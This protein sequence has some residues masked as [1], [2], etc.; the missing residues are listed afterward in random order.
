MLS[1]LITAAALLATSSLAGSSRDCCPGAGPS[2]CP[3]AASSDAPPRRLEVELLALDLAT[4]TR[5]LDASAAIEAALRQLEPVLAEVGMEV[6]FVQRVVRS[7]AEAVKHRLVSSPTLRIQGEDVALELRES[8]CSDCCALADGSAVDC[9]VWLWQGR[10]HSSPPKALFLDALLKGYAR[11]LAAPPASA[12][13]EA[14]FVLPENLRRFFAARANA[15]LHGDAHGSCCG[16]TSTST[17]NT[18]CCD[19]AGR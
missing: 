11:A 9:R 2:C 16:S 10:E 13:S 5:C 4:C 3:G 19:G 18:S 6:R 15:A 12:A 8:R 7:E 17:S 14:P 1:F